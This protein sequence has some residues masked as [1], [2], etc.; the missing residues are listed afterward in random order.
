MGGKPPQQGGPCVHG[1]DLSGKHKHWHREWSRLPTGNLQHSSGAEFT[2]S[3]GVRH[4]A[5]TFDK[6]AAS[7]A[8]RGVPAH[9]L[10]ARLSRLEREGAQWV[11]RNL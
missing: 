6:F 8:A 3:G 4:I 2:T 1:G 10:A 9:D 7:E 5:A 11:E